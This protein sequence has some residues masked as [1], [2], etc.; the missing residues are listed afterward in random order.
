MATSRPPDEASS[1]KSRNE[2]PP[3]GGGTGQQFLQLVDRDDEADTIRGPQGAIGLRAASWARS[4]ARS[5]G[6]AAD[7]D[8]WCKREASAVG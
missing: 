7:T 8:Y 2:N 1:V 5:T 6:A 4:R 3:I